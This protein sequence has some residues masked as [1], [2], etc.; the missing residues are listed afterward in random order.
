MSPT[1]DSGTKT[2]M[3]EITGITL[4]N[5][6]KGHK[7]APWKMKCAIY[8]NVKPQSF[9]WRNGVFSVRILPTLRIDEDISAYH[10]NPKSFYSDKN[11]CGLCVPWN[12]GRQL[13]DDG[14]GVHLDFLICDDIFD[15]PDALKV[16][17]YI[18]EGKIDPELLIPHM[19]ILPE[20]N[21]NLQL[22]KHVLS[23]YLH[24]IR[25]I[26]LIKPNLITSKVIVINDFT[27]IWKDTKSKSRNMAY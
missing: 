17:L 15:K 2:T 10:L 18:Y 22:K 5:E 6:T 12:K 26:A 4:T 8:E 21:I 16:N 23:D 27:I 14:I 20:K 1:S 25:Q 11:F 3:V 7:S 9:F 19:K 13:F 24:L